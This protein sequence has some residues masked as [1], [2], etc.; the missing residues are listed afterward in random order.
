M[1]MPRETGEVCGAGSQELASWGFLPFE[2]IPLQDKES[3]AT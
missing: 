3:N 2:L 1:S